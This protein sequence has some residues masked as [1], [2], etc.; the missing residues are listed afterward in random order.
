MSLR[1]RLHTLLHETTAPVLLGLVAAGAVL[2]VLSFVLTT[3]WL[4]LDAAR[5]LTT[6]AAEKA[7]LAAASDL[8]N[9]DMAA[10]KTARGLITDR[11]V[12]VQ[13]ERGSA[14]PGPEGPAFT[15]GEG[16]VARVVVSTTARSL[17][18]TPVG[19]GQRSI[20][21]TAIAKRA[22]VAALVE[23]ST[24]EPDLPE[25][26]AAIEAALFGP[27][28]ALTPVERDGFAR[29]SFP[30]ASLV[31]S[32]ATRVKP[33]SDPATTPTAAVAGA[34]FK[35]SELF[36]A[37]A[38]IYRVPAQTSV[39][40]AG[41]ETVLRRLSAS[42]ANDKELAIPFSTVISL[43]GSEKDMALTTPVRPLEFL[44][45][46]MRSR[47]ASG[48]V[49]AT[50]DHPV[51]GITSVALDLTSEGAAATALI[52]GEDSFVGIPGIRIAARFRLSG[53]TFAGAQE[54]ELPLRVSLGS[55]D[56]RIKKIVCG[57]SGAEVV[58]T[59]R[60]VR[61]AVLIAEAQDAA[62]GT[63][64]SDYVRLLTAEG[65]AAWGK[66]RSAFADDPPVELLF[67][68]GAGDTVA[69]LRTTI[70]FANRLERLAAETQILVSLEGRA[71]ESMSE[72]G[73]RDELS[74]LIAGAVPS[75]EKVLIS[76]FATFGIMPGK[77]DVVAAGATCNG[78]T[79]LG[80][81]K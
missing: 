21:A 52:G 45:A 31:A 15:P 39:E 26:A 60:P 33:D 10:A 48:Q 46:V 13:A 2:L 16:E 47:L 17:I 53:L 68:P 23:R 18:G 76:T 81:A 71:S 58:V 70:N 36:A 42:A 1:S 64:T 44:R 43:T 6:I 72:G 19:L 8:D 32:L 56:A 69:S 50:L 9:L 75:I 27:T 22:G 29:L 74:N 49:V 11:E 7:A 61:A 78:A 57:P 41:V 65:I 77:M 67:R 51:T 4:R 59:G 38:D 24:A 28:A 62:S 34:S 20:T 12:L 54:L 37:L 80:P 40:L 55:G 79:L 66:G 73:V 3:D 5:R 14:R 25:V 35:P 63:G 30:V